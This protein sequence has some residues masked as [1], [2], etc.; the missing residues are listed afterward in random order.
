MLWRLKSIVSMPKSTRRPP[1]S[2]R[3]SRSCRTRQIVQ[4][5]TALGTPRAVVIGSRASSSRNY[6]SSSSRGRSRP[7]A[8]RP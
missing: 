5:P 7:S 3:K 6:S 2:I 8:N 4:R 1:I